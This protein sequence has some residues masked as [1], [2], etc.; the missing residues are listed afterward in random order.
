MF[1]TGE[2]KINVGCKECAKEG[3]RLQLNEL[4]RAGCLAT[5]LRVLKIP[6]QEAP[7]RSFAEVRFDVSNCRH[8]VQIPARCPSSCSRTTGNHLCLS[9]QEL[10][11]LFPNACRRWTTDEELNL[12]Q[13]FATK[14]TVCEIATAVGRQPSAISHKLHQLG[15]IDCSGYQPCVQKGSCVL[16]KELC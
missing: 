12:R 10:R 14:I 4:P 8:F 2:E 9:L 3:V 11:L 5:G 16:T 6:P 1:A 15:V 7:L 13:L